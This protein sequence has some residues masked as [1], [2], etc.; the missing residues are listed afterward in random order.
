MSV[1]EQSEPMAAEEESYHTIDTSTKQSL[2]DLLYFEQ[3][4]ERLTNLSPAQ[5]RTCRWF[6]TKTEYVA[7]RKMKHHSDG[8]GFLWIKG[9]PGTGKSTLMKLLFEEARLEAKGDRSQITLSFFFL[10]RGAIDL[11]SGGTVYSCRSNDFRGGQA[12][13]RPRRSCS[14]QRSPPGDSML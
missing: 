14:D 4:D 11:E 12:V 9:H 1:E 5:G 13:T 10:A 7:W 8:G 3:I 6:L 2:V